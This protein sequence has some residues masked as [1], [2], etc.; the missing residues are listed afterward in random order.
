MGPAPPAADPPRMYGIPG[1]DHTLKNCIIAAP[2][3]IS[4]TTGSVEWGGA[5][6]VLITLEL[7]LL[8]LTRM[9]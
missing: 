7:L 9:H 3:N 8:E 4:F 2:R 1:G 5:F 6:A